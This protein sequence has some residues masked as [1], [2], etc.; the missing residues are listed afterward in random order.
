MNPVVAIR[1]VQT[2]CVDIGGTGIKAMIVGEDGN[3]QSERCREETPRPATPAAV[4]EVIERLARAAGPYDRVSVGFPG[5]IVHGVV[6]TAPNLDGDWTGF[7]ID[8]HLEKMLGKQVRCAND[9]AVQGLGAIS[10]RGL[11]MMIT[12]GTGLG[13]ALY[14]DGRLVNSLEMAHHP[15]RK[16]KTYEECLGNAALKKA[17]RKKWNKHLREALANWESLVHYDRLYIG[18][19]N[20]EKIDLKLPPNAAIT[21]NM[22]GLLGG[23]ALWNAANERKS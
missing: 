15:F 22:E 1:S 21:S 19:G 23:L 2:L 7:D 14:Q 6:Q 17:G 3:P 16:G 20:A 9:A 18:G 10:G 12:L 13:C 11:E 5:V 4:V 8:G